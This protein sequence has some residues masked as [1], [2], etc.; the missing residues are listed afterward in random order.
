MKK[1]NK[2]M[3]KND[4][5]IGQILGINLTGTTT[6]EVLARVEKNI[7]DSVNFY[8]LTPNPE[9]ILMSQKNQ[10]LKNA[11]NETDLSIPDGVGLKFAIPGLNVIKGRQ[12]FTEL[13]KL[14]N[15]KGWKVFLL[16]GLDGEAAL[17]S[18]KLKIKHQKLNIEYAQG[19]KLDN[20]LE[21]ATEI[22]KK[23]QKEAIEKINKFAPQLLFVAFGN[24]KQEIWVHEHY[25]K[26]NIGGAMA[27]GGA[28]RYIAGLSKLPPK[29][30]AGRGLEWLY[31]L[32]TE[33]RR[34]GRIWNAVI[35]FPLRVFISKIFS[36]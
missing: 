19:P 15:E 20:D 14:A 12:L 31:R 11:L 29:W 7:T 24:P 35:V 18:S 5:K 21:P 32:I 36:I 17:A 30:M 16:G 26:L 13:I 27:V 33:P 8:I 22:D 34:I 28:F 23:L 2:N 10:K 9:I 25:S 1:N 4:H 6:T 3:R